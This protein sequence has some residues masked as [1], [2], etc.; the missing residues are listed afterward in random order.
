MDGRIPGTVPRRS[1]LRAGM[2]RLYRLLTHIIIIKRSLAHHVQF[3]ELFNH[4]LLEVYKN[5]VLLAEMARTG[6]P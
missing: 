2:N 4:S 3:N 1:S 6:K 5:I